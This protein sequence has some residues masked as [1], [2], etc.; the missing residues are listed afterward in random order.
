M[1]ILNSSLISGVLAI[2]AAVIALSA[3]PVLAQGT[4]FPDVPTNHWAYQA[5]TDLANEGYVLGYPDGKFLGGRPMTRYEFATAIDRMVQTVNNLKTTVN[6]LNTAPVTPT[7]VPVTQDDLNK[8]QALVDEFQ[9]QLTTIGSNITDLSASLDALRQDVLDT[10]AYALKANLAAAKAQA[11]ADNS[12]GAGP[13]RKFSISGYIQARY[14]AANSG[15]HTVYPEGN[16]GSAAG[17]GIAAAVNGAYAQ[18]GSRDSEEVRRARIIIAGS[19][20]LNTSYRLQLDMSGAVTTAS[21]ANQQVTVREANGTYT[22][23]DGTAKYP[24]VTAGLFAT[25]FGYV[26]PGSQSTNITPERPLAFSESNNVGLFDNQDYD[27]GVKVGYGLGPVRATYALISGSGRN[28]ETVDNHGDSVLRL[29]YTSPTK[30][31][32]IGTSYYDGNVYRVRP[33]SG[34]EATAD[35]FPQPKKQLVGA[36]AQASYKGF[37]ADYEYVRGTYEKRSYFDSAAVTT[38]ALAI[39][40]PLGFEIDSYVKDNQVQ[41]SYVWAGYT[42]ESATPRPLTLAADYDVFQ[43]SIDSHS[44]GTNALQSNNVGGVYYQSGSSFDDVNLGYGA[45]YN[46]DKATRLRLW[47]DEPFAIAHAPGTATPPKYG[48]Y[49]AELQFKF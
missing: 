18:G 19:P 1:K 29:A 16:N 36:D 10:K 7:G 45:L 17:P 27:K 12:Y 25:P 11:T 33:T 4:S 39:S 21:T 22:F 28:A 13:G 37:F 40:N 8:I 48:L 14:E 44:N 42:F 2:T 47:Y 24:A 6:G 23:G 34:A 15:S 3:Q 9:A 46:F 26:L 32:S 49:T 35:T 43:R 41:G 20:T 31:F 30:I 38:P 5:V